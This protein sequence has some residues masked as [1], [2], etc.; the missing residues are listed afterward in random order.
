MAPH[1]FTRL[2]T[3]KEAEEIRNTM[4]RDVLAAVTYSQQAEL[5]SNVF[6]W[7]EGE[8]SVLH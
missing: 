6:V 1:H 4:F 2:F 8:C 7:S 3:A 5:Q